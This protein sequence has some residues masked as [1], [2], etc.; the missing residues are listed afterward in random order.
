MSLTYVVKLE[1]ETTRVADGVAILVPAP[2][3]R[4]ACTAVST[5]RSGSSS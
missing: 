1:V 4:R 5:S 2:Q 3:S